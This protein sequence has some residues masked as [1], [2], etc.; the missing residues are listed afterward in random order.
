MSKDRQ[1]SEPPSNLAVL[2]ARW[3]SNVRRMLRRAWSWALDNRQLSLMA[4]TVAVLTLPVVGAVVVRSWQAEALRPTPAKMT[5]LALES[6][7]AIDAGNFREARESVEKIDLAYLDQGQL[8]T[9]EFIL[10]ALA[11]DEAEE[12]VGADRRPRFRAAAA[13]LKKS[14]E[15]GFPY[16]HE[17][18]AGFLLGKSLFHSG[19]TSESRSF[20]EESLALLPHRTSEIHGMLA[21][22]YRHSATPDL[23]QALLHNKKYLA[24][25]E[26]SDDQRQEATLRAAELLWKLGDIEGCSRTIARIPKNSS[27]F[28]NASILRGRILLHDADQARAALPADADD[29]AREAVHKQFQETLAV[30]RQAQQDPL[31]TLVIGKAMYL[32]GICYLRLDD[33]KSALEQLRRASRVYENTPEGLA[34]GI[35]EADLLRRLGKHD[36]AVERYAR[37]F[38]DPSLDELAEADN[39]WVSR[40]QLRGRALDAFHYYLRRDDFTRATTLVEHIAPLVQP[41]RAAEMAAELRRNWALDVL[42]AA[43]PKSEPAAS[44]EQAR[45]RR[46]LREAGL[47]YGQAAKLNFSDRQYTENLWQSAEC[48]RQ[49]QNFTAA[50]ARYEE[51]MKYEAKRRR[52]AALMGLGD[53][54]LSLGRPTAAL[55]VLKQCFE[56]L[57][58]DI[59]SYSARL[60]ASRAFGQLGN[61][62]EAEA[63]LRENIGG[64]LLTPASKEWRES[65]FA[66]GKL[67]VQQERHQ[68]AID[69]L[70]EAVARYPQSR[71]SIEARYLIAEE[72]RRAAKVPQQKA[73][74]D[75]IETARVA[76]L[77]EVQ[78][79]LTAA[80]EHYE[81]AQR[82]LNRQREL[83]SLTPLEQAILRNSYF[84]VGM[85]LFDLGRYEDAIRAYSTATN[86]YQHAPEVLEAFVQ[87]AGCYR[88]LSRPMEARGAV[89]QAKVVLSRLPEQAPYEQAT[90][91]TRKQ[92]TELLDWLITL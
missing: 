77:R 20:L 16:Q 84:A 7:K 4:V 63:L 56:M 75:T 39:P 26:L 23:K 2:R 44:E 89:R 22:A 15:L 12:Y 49:G 47:L 73:Q 40:E 14:R 52:S 50:A 59:A 80:I 91:F 31:N 29:K 76:H 43:E 66:L 69:V 21:E 8:T 54:L 64:N 34:A 90:N 24:S 58:H 72:F 32:I 27:A 85:A 42:A 30:L 19:A 10:G 38:A 55:D 3:A 18:E 9:V 68:E 5:N 11:A 45:G 71:P 35:E 33:R 48:Y 78:K 67:L 86:R 60:L 25:A 83:E 74:S 28:A 17:A 57:P 53:C 13:H 87:I 41:S 88:R 36:E 81:D 82:I 1:P 65:L 62:K 79:Y 51:Y 61:P 37:V 70:S 92:W 46:M 6:L